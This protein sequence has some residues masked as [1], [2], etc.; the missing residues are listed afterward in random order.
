MPNLPAAAR[1][2]RNSN[3]FVT[4]DGFV[5]AGGNSRRFGHDKALARGNGRSFVE[6]AVDTLMKAGCNRVV[7]LHRQPAE[8][9]FLECEVLEDLGG[10]QGPLDGLLTALSLARTDLV[11]TLPVDQPLVTSDII[12]QLRDVADED[13]DTD[14]V[15]VTDENGARHHLTAVWRRSTCQPVF[16]RHFSH[17]E[18]SPRR[19]LDDLRCRWVRCPTAL[20]INVNHPEDLP[21][22]WPTLAGE[23]VCDVDENS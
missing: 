2:E 15:S 17:G 22:R 1:P 16:S 10:G 23:G 6:T 21:S 12:R 5:L 7:V 20:L 14:M 19:V 13:P 3:G 18:S 9:G 4:I 11:A 8:L